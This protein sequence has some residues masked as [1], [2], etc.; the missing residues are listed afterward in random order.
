MSQF[1]FAIQKLR[2]GER[3]TIYPK[4]NSM[5]PRIKSGQQVT[6]RPVNSKT[7]IRKDDVVLRTVN[8]KDYL[9]LVIG[10]DLKSGRF[11]IGNNK[12]GVNGWIPRSKIWG[13]I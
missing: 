12:G 10:F 9:H 3:V 11:R 1:T 13:I 5:E 7:I 6:V 4:G 2:K 8:G